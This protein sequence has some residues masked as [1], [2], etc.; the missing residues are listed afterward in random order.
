MEFNEATWLQ[1]LPRLERVKLP[2]L[3]GVK[4]ARL[5]L[6]IGNRCRSASRLVY[7]LLGVYFDYNA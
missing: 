7:R 3:A 1:V 5:E 6:I 4:L 2:R